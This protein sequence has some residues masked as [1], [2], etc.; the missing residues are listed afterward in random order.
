MATLEG[1]VFQWGMRNRSD[2]HS[3]DTPSD[4]VSNALVAA[5]EPNSAIEPSPGQRLQDEVPLDRARM[6]ESQA[7]C[8]FSHAGGD[9]PMHLAP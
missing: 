6:R 1:K 3:T 9:D 7:H 4:V 8:L 5:E 2:K